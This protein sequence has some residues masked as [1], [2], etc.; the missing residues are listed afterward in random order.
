MVA[1]R[2]KNKLWEGRAKS[3]VNRTTQV[4]GSGYRKWVPEVVLKP[5][6]REQEQPLPVP[7]QMPSSMESFATLEN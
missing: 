3:L 5:V 4:K 7:I 6:P 2:V 1:F